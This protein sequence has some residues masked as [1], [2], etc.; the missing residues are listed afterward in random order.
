MHMEYL[1]NCS[2][3][4]NILSNSAG[5]VFERL[6]GSSWLGAMPIRNR[7]A[8]REGSVWKRV[9]SVERGVWRRVKTVRGEWECR[10]IRDT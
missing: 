5:E 7:C 8:E 6:R 2:W 9:R 1:A 10:Y 4:E 3:R